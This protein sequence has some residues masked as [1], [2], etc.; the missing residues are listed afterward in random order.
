MKRWPMWISLIWGL[1]ITV[2]ALIA[3]SELLGAV[4]AGAIVGFV[5][6]VPLALLAWLF[7]RLKPARSRHPSEAK[8]PDRS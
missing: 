6:Y 4:V 7:G 2:I 3:G 8:R 1:L 5:I